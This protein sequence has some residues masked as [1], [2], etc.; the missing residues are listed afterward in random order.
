MVK[1]KVPD[2]LSEIEIEKRRVASIQRLRQLEKD[3][4]VVDHP[5]G[6]IFQSS[7]ESDEEGGRRK[8][9]KP[10]GV[11]RSIKTVDMMLMSDPLVGDSF[12]SIESPLSVLPP[13]KLCSVCSN[14]AAYTCTRCSARFCSIPCLTIHRDTRCLKYA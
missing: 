5:I 13:L 4:S 12:A 9:K 1:K 3:Q 11:V 7:D 6:H 8:S 2:G 14:K 10:R